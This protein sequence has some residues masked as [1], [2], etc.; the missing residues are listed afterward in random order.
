LAAKPARRADETHP[1]AAARS[2]SSADEAAMP[3]HGSLAC[4][5]C[6]EGAFGSWQRGGTPS[7]G[8]R[9]GILE[10]AVARAASAL[11]PGW[12]DPSA[13]GGTE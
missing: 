7:G 3:V 4:A 12:R 2:T 11:A 10:A 9:R 6:L 8:K 13:G 5:P 1:R